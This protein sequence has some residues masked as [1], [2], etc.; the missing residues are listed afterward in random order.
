MN[1]RSYSGT[2]DSQA[3]AQMTKLLS[4]LTC[5]QSNSAA[6]T[7]TTAATSSSAN[8]FTELESFFQN[9][10]SSDTMGGLFQAQGGPPPGPAPGPPPGQSASQAGG[11]TPPSL[12]DID[13]DGDGSLTQSE[14]QAY[15]TSVRGDTDTTRADELFGKM[16][17]D[18]DGTV[19]AD[20]KTTFDSQ[21]APR[22][23]HGPGE[24]PQSGAAYPTDDNMSE[25][26]AGLMQQLLSALQSYSSASAATASAAATTT[27]V[28][29]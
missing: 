21:M 28:A 15:G 14:M 2:G 3:L 19:T 13:S 16:D 23:Q 5:S 10:L 26:L 17:T 12:S 11:F 7:E 25:S 22:A 24:P 20:E 18:G 29:A 4:Q 6:T 9:S 8:L 1:I 27:S